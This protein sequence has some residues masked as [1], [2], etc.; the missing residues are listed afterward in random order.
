VSPKGYTEVGNV[1]KVGGDEEAENKA[2]TSLRDAG[3]SQ[4]DVAMQYGDF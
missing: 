3:P 1:V 4:Y 2:Q